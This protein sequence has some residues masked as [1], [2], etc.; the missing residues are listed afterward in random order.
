M[1]FTELVIPSLV[2]SDEAR[3][4]FNNNILPA[5]ISMASQFP[6]F[7]LSV[8][9]QISI[10]NNEAVL[11]SI[12]QPFLSLEWDDSQS[13]YNATQ[14]EKFQAFGAT[15]KSYFTAPPSPQ[16]YETDISPRDIFASPVTDVFRINIR[17]DPMREAAAKTAWGE[18]VKA[19]G[20]AKVLN[21]QRERTLEKAAH[22]KKNLEKLDDAQSFTPI[23]QLNMLLPRLLPNS[24]ILS[25]ASTSSRSSFQDVTMLS[26]RHSSNS[27][28]KSLR[29]VTDDDRRRIYIMGTDVKARFLAYSLA[30]LPD[31][32]PVTFLALS[33]EPFHSFEKGETKLTMLYQAK[34]FE[35]HTVAGVGM[36]VIAQTSHE[37]EKLLNPKR[38]IGSR[39]FLAAKGGVK[40]IVY[41]VF[42]IVTA[43][44]PLDERDREYLKVS[45]DRIESGVC[46]DGNFDLSDASRPTFLT[47]SVNLKLSN[48]PKFR[49]T[50]RTALP[51]LL[52]YEH[53]A[54]SEHRFNG[55]PK[56]DESNTQFTT[57][58]ADFSYT[59]II[60]G[61]MPKNHGLHISDYDGPSGRQNTS[62]YLLKCLK[63]SM[64]HQLYDFFHHTK[65][66]PFTT[67]YNQ[68]RGTIC[69]DVVE[70]LCIHF[71]CQ[72][73]ELIEIKERRALAVKLIV[74]ALK[75]T[76]QYLPAH[77][78]VRTVA[79][80]LNDFIQAQERP[81]PFPV[82][83]DIGNG[84]AR[85][86]DS[87]WLIRHGKQLR[88]QVP[89]PEH[90]R[91]LQL[92]KDKAKM[93]RHR[94]VERLEKAYAQRI[95]SRRNAKVQRLNNLEYKREKEEWR[96][97]ENL[98]KQEIPVNYTAPQIHRLES[99]ERIS[100][101][102]NGNGKTWFANTSLFS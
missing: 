30:S 83:I 66:D 47:T 44:D 102:V 59:V 84:I 61:F 86:H 12:F 65:H 24:V 93:Q 8:S 58:D 91:L 17:D 96:I 79:N 41:P 7:M 71:D 20:D 36:E 81:T 4:A 16:V 78:D 37:S 80:W 45:P 76:R 25:I 90:E 63:R 94:E 33:P 68:I 18:L 75:V 19:L 89:C 57:E 69:R 29:P 28:S 46:D 70:L 67:T 5:L 60:G 27:A 87:E 98:G 51:P 31:P 74:E 43:L 55:N 13:F 62:H 23:T 6:G 10:E 21:G 32:P 100:V 54:A 85:F 3:E 22:L 42:R 52:Q 40:W 73:N 9:G 34:N 64:N 82:L 92:A 15:F 49:H 56:I 2:Q 1:T 38:D 99:L 53:V 39:L 11:E 101:S 14:S 50:F 26:R 35:K 48:P 95:Q 88:P 77:F 72:P 97:R